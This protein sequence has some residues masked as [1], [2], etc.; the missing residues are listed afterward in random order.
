MK[1][2]Y[3][4]SDIQKIFEVHYSIFLKVVNYLKELFTLNLY[5]YLSYFLTN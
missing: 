4:F 2:N 1:H 3:L 5:L